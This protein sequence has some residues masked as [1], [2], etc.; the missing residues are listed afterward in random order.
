MA[1]NKLLLARTN[2]GMTGFPELENIQSSF[3][4]A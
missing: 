4:A 3:E 2:Q 1:S